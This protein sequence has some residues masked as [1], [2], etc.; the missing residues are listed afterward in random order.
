M[1][2]DLRMLAAAG[3][4]LTAMA[5]ADAAFAQKAGGILKMYSP[6]SPASMSIH[7]EATFVAEGPMMGVFNNLVVFDQHVKQN[8]LDS[9]VPE[10]A[11]GWS[12]ARLILLGGQPEMRTQGLGGSEASGIVDCRGIGERD[13]G[14]GVCLPEP[15]RVQPPAEHPVWPGRLR[16]YGGLRCSARS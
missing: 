8:S 6:D 10:L 4:L 15:E 12:C 2:R 5:T 3:A 7:E 1:K 9:I 16:L 14:A 11:T 13:D